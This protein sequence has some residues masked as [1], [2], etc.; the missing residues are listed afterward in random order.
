V[1]IALAVRVQCRG[2]LS[3]IVKSRGIFGRSPGSLLQSGHGMPGWP[4]PQARLPSNGNVSPRV[5][6]RERAGHG[7]MAKGS[8]FGVRPDRPPAVMG[9]SY[10]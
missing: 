1:A 5:E 2:P 8:R 3:S 9:C 7:G 10:R 4:Q 6:G